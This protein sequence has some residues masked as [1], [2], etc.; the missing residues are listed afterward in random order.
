MKLYIGK[1]SDEGIGT[2]CKIDSAKDD[3]C[4]ELPLDPPESPEPPEF[5]EPPPVSPAPPPVPPPPV[6]AGV[7]DVPFHVPPLDVHSVSAHGPLA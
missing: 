7:Q 3:P 4:E 1:R 6:E 5:P 2:V